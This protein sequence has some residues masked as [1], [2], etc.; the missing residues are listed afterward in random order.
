MEITGTII[1]VTPV[2][3][4]GSG[5]KPWAKRDF[6]IETD[7]KYPKKVCITLW[8]QD[9]ID[10]YDLAVGS[11]ITASIEI[12]SREYNGKWYTNVKAWK[13]EGMA[14]VPQRERQP[15][16]KPTSSGTWPSNPVVDDSGDQLP[17]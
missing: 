1:L 3:T 10:K 9:N 5:A 6:V 17:F 16:P 8:G 2:T 14:S 12:E 13:I 11:T 4:G 7:G 15:E